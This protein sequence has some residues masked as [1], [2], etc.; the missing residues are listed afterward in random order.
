MNDS[1]IHKAPAPASLLGTPPDVPTW[2][3]DDVPELLRHQLDTPLATDLLAAPSGGDSKS[4]P[5]AGVTFGEVLADA[6]APLDWLRRVKDFAKASDQPPSPALPPPVATVLYYAALIA[7]D[8]R[9]GVW[10]T[11]LTRSQVSSCE[12][13]S[14]HRSAWVICEIRDVHEFV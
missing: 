7:A 13:L 1:G 5:F 11:S 9:H 2:R 12:S 8:L 10:L 3:A 4:D 6:Q 14:L